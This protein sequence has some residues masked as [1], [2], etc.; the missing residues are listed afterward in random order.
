MRLPRRAGGEAPQEHAAEVDAFLDHVGRWAA[1]R[2]DVAAV[3]LVGSWAR[4]EAQAGS[5]VDLVVLTHDPAAYLE[6][7]GWIEQLAPGTRLVRAASWGAID[8]RRL[9]LP[10]GLEVEV[11]VGRPSWADTDPVD[12][13]TRRVVCD[14]LRP[15]FDP[16]GLLAAVV[17]AC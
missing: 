16:A 9:L 12:P 13:G 3:A 2:G 10:S 11:G 5:D 4:G 1:S 17:A 7:D 14:G 8:E 6:H 15:V